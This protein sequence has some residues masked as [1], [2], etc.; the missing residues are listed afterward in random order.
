MLCWKKNS[1]SQAYTYKT[2]YYIILFLLRTVSTI[3]DVNQSSGHFKSSL[4]NPFLNQSNG[5]LMFLSYLGKT[6]FPYLQSSPSLVTHRA[7]SHFWE[8]QL[9]LTCQVINSALPVQF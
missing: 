3:T 9:S 1:N 4:Y 5:N 6:S 2:A 8:I 7:Q